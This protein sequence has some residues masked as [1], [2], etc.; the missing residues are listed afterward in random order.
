MGITFLTPTYPA[1]AAVLR[2]DPYFRLI[3]VTDQS[4]TDDENTPS[5]T[6]GT[7]LAWR[8]PYAFAAIEVGPTSV[9]ANFLVEVHPK[10]NSQAS[11]Y[12]SLDPRHPVV[13]PNT[14][15]PS[16]QNADAGSTE[17]YITTIW[18]QD[19]YGNASPSPYE[20][21]LI[22]WLQ[23]PTNLSRGR[24]AQTIKI[25]ISRSAGQSATVFNGYP[26]GAN[27]N[28][29]PTLFP[30]Q[31]T[32]PSA[33]IMGRRKAIVNGYNTTAQATLFK[34]WGQRWNFDSGGTTGTLYNDLIFSYTTSG[35]A[36]DSFTFV[37]DNAAAAYQYIGYTVTNQS[38]V[39][40]MTGFL[41][42]T[43][44]D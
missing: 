29:S 31:N 28:L 38:G 14:G 30:Q 42:I 19:I 10:E 3:D 8:F 1:S 37:L 5:Y 24:P 21:D 20:V 32:Y 35:S 18:A 16:S 12:F 2:G 13:F 40:A 11:Q 15:A 27:W 9:L 43:M 7:R 22:C 25:P 33:T 39:T 26:N 41:Q 34:I 44:I 17:K 6:T 23:P 36:G 4:A